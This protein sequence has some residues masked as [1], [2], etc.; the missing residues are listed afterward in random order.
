[1]PFRDNLKLTNKKNI[2]F[3]LIK[4]RL[5]VLTVFWVSLLNEFRESVEKMNESKKIQFDKMM[6]FFL[7]E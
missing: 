3:E 4:N 5:S 1:M 7:N 2:N 6:E